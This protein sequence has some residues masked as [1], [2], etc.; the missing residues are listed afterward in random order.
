MYRELGNRNDVCEIHIFDPKDYS[1][2][3]LRGRGMHFHA[4]GLTSSY[5]TNYNGTEK[6]PGNYLSLPETME[7]LGHVGRVIDIFKIDCEGCEWFVFKDLLGTSIKSHNIDVRQILVE[8]H[9]LPAEGGD[10]T[11]LD[12][13][14][15][16]AQSGFALFSKEVNIH[17]AANNRC[18]E[19]SYVKLHQDFWR[20]STA[21]DSKISTQ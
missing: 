13:F 11:P 15:A 3:S 10:V 12:Y 19:W 14:D 20:Q 1:K 7:R 8:T 21:I 16:F 5:S 4:W 2:R 9:E 18:V 6:A 17:P